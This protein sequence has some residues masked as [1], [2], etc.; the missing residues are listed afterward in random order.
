MFRPCPVITATAAFIE[1]FIEE[2]LEHVVTVILTRIVRAVGKRQAERQEVAGEGAHRLVVPEIKGM[3]ALFATDLAFALP[4]VLIVLQAV[5]RIVGD[6]VFLCGGLAG[7]VH[8]EVPA[9]AI[10][11]HGPA[12]GLVEFGEVEGSCQGETYRV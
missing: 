7:V 10:A 2:M 5:I 9:Q 11:A 1:A 4:P 3:T 6:R 12:E 8:A